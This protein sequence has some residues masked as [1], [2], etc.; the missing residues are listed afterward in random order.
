MKVN[1]D[2]WLARFREKKM[3]IQHGNVELIKRIEPQVR[4]LRQAINL[5]AH[6]TFGNDWFNKSNTATNEDRCPTVQPK[7]EVLAL[8]R[9]LIELQGA[10]L[11]CSSLYEISQEKI[12]Q[13]AQVTGDQQWLHTDPDRAKRE[14]PFR[15]TVAHGLLLLSL[16]PAMRAINE[17]KRYQTARF[18]VNQGI[19]DVRFLAPVKPGSSIK[20]R[21]SLSCVSLASR[22]LDIVEDIIIENQSGS[23]CVCSAAMVIKIYL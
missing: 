12:N 7:P 20:L 2:K 1:Y 5:S 9:Q 21:S 19:N 14:S 22:H 15:S 17:D 4:E 10:E 18:I 23:R 11:H 6:N 3:Q 16:M 13:F 8:Y